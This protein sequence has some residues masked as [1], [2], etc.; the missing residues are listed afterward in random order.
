MWCLSR[1]LPL[2]IGDLVPEHDECWQNF[3]RLLKI[4]ELV[5][6]PVTSTCLAAFLQVLIEEYLLEFRRIHP[7]RQMIPKQHYMVHYPRFLVR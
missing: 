2:L 7:D 6:S 4:E 1:L 5:F 3:L